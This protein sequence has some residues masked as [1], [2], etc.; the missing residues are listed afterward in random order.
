M[1][2]FTIQSECKHRLRDR[3][4]TFDAAILPCGRAV[5]DLRKFERTKAA[6]VSEWEGVRYAERV[7]TPGGTRTASPYNRW[8]AC[9]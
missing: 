2:N 6:W 8:H 5:T 3:G 1:L 7:E 9:F 4:K